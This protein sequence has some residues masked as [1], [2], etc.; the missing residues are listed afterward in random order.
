MNPGVEEELEELDIKPDHGKIVKLSS[1][2]P[3]PKT[4]KN[5]GLSK[6]LASNN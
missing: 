5:F 4:T 3:R 1:S 2:S 6:L